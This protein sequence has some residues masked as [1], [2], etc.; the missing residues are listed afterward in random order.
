MVNITGEWVEF[1]FF[2]PEAV[3]VHLAGEF[4]DWRLSDLPMVRGDDGYWKAR[5]KLPPGEFRFRYCSDGV[6]FTDYAAFGVEPGMFG[7]DSVVRVPRRSTA[8]AL[9]PQADAA[10]DEAFAAA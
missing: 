7:L 9:T 4:N 10:S 8:V 6:W 2:R 5:V 1:R 3:R